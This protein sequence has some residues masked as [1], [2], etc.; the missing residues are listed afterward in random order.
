[1]IG[2]AHAAGEFGGRPRVGIDAFAERYSVPVDL[3]IRATNFIETAEHPEILLIQRP[4]QETKAS[5]IALFSSVWSHAY[6]KVGMPF[7]QV[8]RDYHYIVQFATISILAEVGCDQIR[9]E[10]PMSGY[11]WRKEAYICLVEA[12]ENVRKHIAKVVVHLEKETYDP[13]LIKDIDDHADQYD[14]QE[15]RAIHIVP[16]LFEGFNM[17]TVYINKPSMPHL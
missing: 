14:L 1:M 15:H 12:L 7:G 17:C 4:Y 3:L 9:V 11:V 6:G 2:Y 10:N 5:A 13:R 8:H 16:H